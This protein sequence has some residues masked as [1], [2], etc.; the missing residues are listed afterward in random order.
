VALVALASSLI[1][2]THLVAPA[3]A[4]AFEICVTKVTRLG[5]TKLKSKLAI[6]KPCPAKF[7][8]S[9]DPASA[10]SK[11]FKF[12]VPTDFLCWDKPANGFGTPGNGVCDKS[13]DEKLNE[14]LDHDGFCTPADCQ[15]PPCFDK[16]V[17]LDC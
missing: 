11:F 12:E 16:D 10:T 5:A 7:V 9:R 17:Q 8:S 1:L 13:T 2:A 3:I 4:T 15:G 14:D 6:Q